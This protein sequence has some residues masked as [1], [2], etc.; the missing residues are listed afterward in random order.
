LEDVSNILS[1]WFNRITTGMLKVKMVDT[2]TGRG[3][4]GM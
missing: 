3:N 1:K 4:A 2:N